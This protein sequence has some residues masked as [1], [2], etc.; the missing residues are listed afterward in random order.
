MKMTRL[1]S[2][3]FAA[4][5]AAFLMTVSAAAYNVSVYD[6]AELFS[7]DEYSE[8]VS[9]AEEVSEN[10]S[11]NILI[12]TVSGDPGQSVMSYA[13]DN[14]E[15][16][17]GVNAS[18]V[19]I[20]LNPSNPDENEDDVY[21]GTYGSAITLIT[22]GRVNKF[23]DDVFPYYDDYRDADAVLTGLDTLNRFIAEGV[24]DDAAVVEGTY[25]DN[26]DYDSEEAGDSGI[27]AVTIVSAVVFAAIVS[28]IT[29]GCIAGSYKFHAKQSANA[30][31]DKG[32]LNMYRQKDMFLR[33]THT[34]TKIDRSSGSS[35]GSRSRSHTSSTHR[36]SGGG[37]AGGGGRSS[38]RR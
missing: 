30:Y 36:T 31:L 25:D 11:W 1:I 32:N 34:R 15:S 26:Y 27:A 16:E 12:M 35:G 18:G 33:E 13:D 21:L 6:D 37:R 4:V 23:L 10:G 29:V 8:I 14:Y 7:D 19:C 20:V 3:A 24:Y 17:N 9:K 2:A 5:S 22:D 38:S 28:G